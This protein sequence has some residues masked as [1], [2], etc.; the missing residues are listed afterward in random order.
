MPGQPQSP[1]AVSRRAASV[2]SP[3]LMACGA[4]IAG[5]SGYV[6]FLHAEQRKDERE[7]DKALV[8]A[9]TALTVQIAE[10]KTLMTALAALLNVPI[11]RNPGGVSVTEKS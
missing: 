9:L 1:H 3:E 11:T 7:N 2:L 10:V 8:G 5:L 6:A 4:A